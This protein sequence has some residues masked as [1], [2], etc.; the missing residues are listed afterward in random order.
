DF[1]VG[2]YTGL[3]Y[4][5]LFNDTTLFKTRVGAGAAWQ[6]DT[7]SGGPPDQWVPEGILGVDFNHKFTER[8]GFIS[9]VDLYPNLSRLGQYRVRS[10]AGYEIVI[11]PNHGMVLRLGV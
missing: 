2:A 9:S 10:R 7:L 8:Q 5:W 3:A 1:R 6:T 11:D 4:R